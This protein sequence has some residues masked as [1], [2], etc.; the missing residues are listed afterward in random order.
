M[1]KGLIQVYTGDGKGKTTAAIGLSC[2]AVAHNLKVCYICF[3]KGL[4]KLVYGEQ[5]V[6]KKL[7]I[8]IY[9]FAEKH[10]HCSKNINK[11]EVRKEC[12]KGLEFIRNIYQENRFD[13]L[14]LDEILIALRDNFLTEEEVV[15]LLN[16]KPDN[17]ELI[18]TGRGAREKI[19]EKADLVSEI[20][21]IKHP[22]DNGIKRR[23]GIEY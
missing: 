12:L 11:E 5:K 1:H 15:E 21:N 22:Y 18:L 3:F 23:K 10:P 8:A 2:R 19:I 20:K 13:I 4:K 16:S 17:L 9:K 14:I 6:L 7:G